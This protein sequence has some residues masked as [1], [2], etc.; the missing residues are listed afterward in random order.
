VNPG[1]SKLVPYWHLSRARFL[2]G[3]PSRAS[4]VRLPFNETPV[5]ATYLHTGF[6]FGMLSGD[7]P[8][9]GLLNY[10]I[11]LGAPKR[12]TD[13]LNVLPLKLMP[14]IAPHELGLQ[15][16]HDWT[17]GELGAMTKSGLVA[18]IAGALAERNYL[19][20]N[21]NYFYLPG[22]DFY[23]RN[24][25][26]QSALVIGFD[27]AAREFRVACYLRKGNFGITRIPG[28]LLADAFYSPLG[29]ASCSEASKADR[30]CGMKNTAIA[31]TAPLD[32]NAIKWQLIDYVAATYA[33]PWKVENQIMRRWSDRYDQSTA[34]DTY[35]GV[36]IYQG[37]AELLRTADFKALKKI[38]F[39]IT[40]LL[41]EHKKLMSIRIRRLM[42]RGV[43]GGSGLL[44]RWL[45]VERLAWT[46]HFSLFRS[47]VKNDTIDPDPIE[48]SLRE[49]AARER[50]ILGALGEKLP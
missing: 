10:H 33:A 24:H 2:R 43:I 44:D 18:A 30:L 48:R 42:E 3:G 16:L 47:M 25:F 23:R 21:I 6:F 5:V 17:P 35:Y 19:Y 40:R 20:A 15:E 46:L 4:S 39:R 27:A 1:L 36:D 31:F 11:Q 14:A 28:L 38:D 50:D 37:I 8:C 45:E 7:L 9:D 41:W 22:T 34:A 32:L 26:R 12:R 49:M 29:R 13:K